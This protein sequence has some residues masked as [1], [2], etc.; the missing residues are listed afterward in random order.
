MVTEA[1]TGVEGE[2]GSFEKAGGGRGEEGN[3]EGQN[4]GRERR[5]ETTER[6]T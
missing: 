4:E 3:K 1:R 5:I 2:M 6:K